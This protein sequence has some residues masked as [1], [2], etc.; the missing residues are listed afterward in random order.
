MPK[1]MDVENL[2]NHKV[3]HFGF[4]AVSMDDLEAAGYTL[5]TIVCDRSGST[6]GFQQD[7]EKALKASVEA[8]QESKTFDPETVMLRVLTIDNDVE[9]QHGY[10]PLLD[11]DTDRY[12]GILSAR[13]M[14]ALFDGC[15][16]AA[17]AASNYGLQLRRDHYNANGIMIVITDGANNAGKFSSPVDVDEVKKAFQETQRSESLESFTSILI[18]VNALSYST[19][20]RDFHADAGFT[21]PV[22]DLKDASPETIAKIGDFIV[23][24]VSSTST[25]LGTGGPSQTIKF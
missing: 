24:S 21:V 22:V 6:S 5:A 11:I 13:G 3:G 4:T 14:T 8:L 20:L 2:E 15:V 19:V 9:E 25:A 23:S 12:D 16:D 7:M 18:A 1:L 17:Q 10:I